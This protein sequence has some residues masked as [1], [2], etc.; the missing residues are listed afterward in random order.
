MFTYR[1]NGHPHFILIFIVHYTEIV[2]CQGTT[3]WTQT[4][5][6]QVWMWYLWRDVWYKRWSEV[7]FLQSLQ[8]PWMW[9]MWRDV[10]YKRSSQDMLLQTPRM[11]VQ[12]IFIHIESASNSDVV[13]LSLLVIFSN[14]PFWLQPNSFLYCILTDPTNEW[15]CGIWGS[16]IKI[17]GGAH[18]HGHRLKHSFSLTG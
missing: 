1:F 12:S 16:C 3:G 7:M 17:W 11:Y 10:W 6:S 18:I 15:W 13:V 4:D 5:S 8:L 14:S 9:Y 2:L